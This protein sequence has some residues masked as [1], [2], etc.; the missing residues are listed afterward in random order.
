MWNDAERLRYDPAMRLDVGGKP[1]WGHA[2]SPSQIGRFETQWALLQTR[3]FLLCR[4]VGQWIALCMP[5]TA[6]LQCSTWI[7]A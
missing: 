6:P 2:A 5:P 7:R 1:S 3:T 4:L